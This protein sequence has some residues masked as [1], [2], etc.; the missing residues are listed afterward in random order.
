ML[1]LNWTSLSSEKCLFLMIYLTV[2]LSYNLSEAH[3]YKWP[4]P[5]G[6][7]DGDMITVKGSLPIGGSR[8]HI[9]FA[10]ENDLAIGDIIFHIDYRYAQDL[11]V[12]NTRNDSV[13]WMA[14]ERYTGTGAV[15]AGRHFTILIVLRFNQYMVTTNGRH[16]LTFNVRKPSS[17]T[18]YMSI[19]ADVNLSSVTFESY[20]M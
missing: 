18:K 1:F 16:F 15:V 6:H 5:T 12:L 14:E 13:N 11:I 20:F 9:T 17:Y 10:T 8:F 4:L 7:N 3:S 19:D 2:V